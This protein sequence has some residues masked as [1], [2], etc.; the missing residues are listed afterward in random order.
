[1]LGSASGSLARPR[2]RLG[3]SIGAVVSRTAG[4]IIL[5]EALTG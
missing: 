1:M 4:D 5:V 2:L 3:Q